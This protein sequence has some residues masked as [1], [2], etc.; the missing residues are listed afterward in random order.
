MAAKDPPCQKKSLQCDWMWG[1]QKAGRCFLTNGILV[2]LSWSHII[3]CLEAIFSK[4]KAK[5]IL[6]F[7]FVVVDW[8]ILDSVPVTCFFKPAVASNTKRRDCVLG[9]VC[10]LFPVFVPELCVMAMHGSH[11]N[12]TLGDQLRLYPSIT[13]FTLGHGGFWQ[14]GFIWIGFYFFVFFVL[15]FVFVFAFSFVWLVAL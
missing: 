3:E 10:N 4:A 15:I 5:R 9:N 8:L 6:I 12:H 11:E 14:M 7:F 1:F 13:P 2:F